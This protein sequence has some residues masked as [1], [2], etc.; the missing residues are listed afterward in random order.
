MFGQNAKNKLTREDYEKKLYKDVNNDLVYLKL[1]LSNAQKECE[2]ALK[3]YKE[4][5]TKISDSVIENIKKT[6]ETKI[7]E[8][9][10]PVPKRRTC[11]FDCGSNE[12]NNFDRYSYYKE[13]IDRLSNNI[14][15]KND[16]LLE[17][18]S[19]IN[20]LNRRNTLDYRAINAIYNRTVINMAPNLNITEGLN[21]TYDKYLFGFDEE[22][23]FANILRKRIEYDEPVQDILRRRNE[24]RKTIESNFEKQDWYN[25]IDSRTHKILHNLFTKAIDLAETSD[26]SKDDEKQKKQNELSKISSDE[27][28]WFDNVDAGCTYRLVN[29]I[30]NIQNLLKKLP[31]YTD[32]ENKVFFPLN[33]HVSR[34]KIEKYV[35][36]QRC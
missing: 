29:P 19:Q 34:N 10:A 35:N 28:T 25:K 1:G 6:I 30:G 2:L 13:D 31:E 24:M 33:E 26:T 3:N 36:Q 5:E 14:S 23:E 7:D 21:E 4:Q 8:E 9:D 12:S 20:V 17:I 22:V 32:F 15:I 27:K 18:E 16:K 11:V